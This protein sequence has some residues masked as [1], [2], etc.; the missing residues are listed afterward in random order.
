MKYILRNEED[1]RAFNKCTSIDSWNQTIRSMRCDAH[2]E[3]PGFRFS[4]KNPMTGVSSFSGEIEVCCEDFG[5]KIVEKCRN[6][7]KSILDLRF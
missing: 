5:K 3:R 1:H 2:D 6:I 7:A 4:G